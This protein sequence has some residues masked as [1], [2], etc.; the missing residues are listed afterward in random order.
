MNGI[1]NKNVL[2]RVKKN[3]HDDLLAYV[4]LWGNSKDDIII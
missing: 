1:N 3:I 4:Q 2:I